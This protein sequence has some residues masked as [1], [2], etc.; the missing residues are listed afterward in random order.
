MR[1]ICAKEGMVEYYIA[2]FKSRT[3]AF[4]FSNFLAVNQ[5]PSSLIPTPKEAGRTCGISVKILPEDYE[6]AKLVLSKSRKS[7]FVGWYYFVIR[8]GEKIIVRA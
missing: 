5:I 2:V 7:S 8:N 3:E 1:G 6:F 4:S